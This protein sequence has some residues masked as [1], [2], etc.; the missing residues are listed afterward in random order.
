MLACLALL[1]RRNRIQRIKFVPST[2]IRG[3]LLLN[4]VDIAGTYVLLFDDTNE[5]WALALDTELTKKQ[6]NTATS[7]T[8]ISQSSRSPAPDPLRSIHDAR[9]SSLHTT[10]IPKQYGARRSRYTSRQFRKIQRQLVRGRSR[11][12][13]GRTIQHKNVSTPISNCTTSSTAAWNKFEATL[14]G[15]CA[16]PR[17]GCQQQFTFIF[18]MLQ[19]LKSVADLEPN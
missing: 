8:D 14:R 6:L 19:I 10:D 9:T 2:S 17:D 13:A 7:D 4:E 16:G 12:R 11:I 15:D 1:A 3:S 18:R 5:S